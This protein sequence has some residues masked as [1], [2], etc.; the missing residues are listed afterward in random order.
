LSEADAA[1]WARGEAHTVLAGTAWGR[2]GA[3]TYA[4]HASAGYVIVLDN[5]MDGRAPARVRLTVQRAPG[6]LG[7]GT[8]RWPGRGKRQT[9]VAGSCVL[10][11]AAAAFTAWKLRR[12]TR[13]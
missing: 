7:I 11:A 13:G 2:R 8:V 5:R 3:F 10:F 1:R 4:T 6:S 9:L 12:A